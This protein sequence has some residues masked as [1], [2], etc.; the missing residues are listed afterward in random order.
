MAMKA[1]ANDNLSI[2]MT[3]HSNAFN[4]QQISSKLSQAESAFSNK[5]LD[6]AI[7][8]SNEV[9]NTL[10]AQEKFG[11]ELLKDALLIDYKARFLKKLGSRSIHAIRRG[12]QTSFSHFN[13]LIK[14][15]NENLTPHQRQQVK[16]SIALFIYEL[17]MSSRRNPAVSDDFRSKDT[18][19]RYIKSATYHTLIGTYK[20]PNKTLQTIVSNPQYPLDEPVKA[21]FYLGREEMI[22]HRFNRAENFLK[23][24]INAEDRGDGYESYKMLAIDY[25]YHLALRKKDLFS[26]NLYW[27]QLADAQPTIVYQPDLVVAEY[28]DI[29]QLNTQQIELELTIDKMGYVKNAVLQQP[30]TSNARATFNFVESTLL[31]SRFSPL[32]G[33]DGSFTASTI[34]LSVEINPAFDRVISRKQTNLHRALSEFYPGGY[35]NS[36]LFTQ[37]INP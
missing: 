2:K 10:E 12:S 27:L 22:K 1:N 15:A 20:V 5:N 3:N 7:A 14:H 13:P 34:S 21:Y 31:N 18:R 36:E 33:N 9:I 19:S 6:E 17:P 8:Q 25:L 35:R 4:E 26:A 24:V 30:V 37:L 29:N 28:I 11:S 32:R 16:E 23:Q